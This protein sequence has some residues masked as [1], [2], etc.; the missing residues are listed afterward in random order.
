[1]LNGINKNKLSL[2]LSSS[3]PRSLFPT[4]QSLFNFPLSIPRHLCNTPLS[5]SPCLLVNLSFTSTDSWLLKF[6]LFLERVNQI[7]FEIKHQVLGECN[8]LNNPMKIRDPNCLTEH[9]SCSVPL[10]KPDIYAPSP[11]PLQMH[12]TRGRM[13]APTSS[14]QGVFKGRSLRKVPETAI[15]VLGAAVFCPNIFIF[16]C[17]KIKYF[18]LEYYLILFNFPENRGM[19]EHLWYTLHH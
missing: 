17:T 16:A 18:L 2:S 8:G 12:C 5:K 19:Q 15:G 11:H 14:R 3:L 13:H 7:V 6:N 9:P 10:P 4:H 1:M